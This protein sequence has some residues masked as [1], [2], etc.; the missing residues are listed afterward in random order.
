[1]TP[2]VLVNADG[3][4]DA[5]LSNLTLQGAGSGTGLQ[6]SNG[7]T[8]IRLE[9]TVVQDM[10]TAVSVDGATT[11]LALKNNTVVANVNGFLASN[12]AG[13]D[14]RNTIFAYNSGTAVQYDPG[15]VLQLH[16]YNLYYAN[17]TDLNPNNPGGGERFS[18]P[19]FL[20]FS[21]GDFRTELF[22]PVIDAGTPNDLVPPGAGLAV[23]IGHREQTGSSFFADDDYCDVCLNDGLIW[24]VDAFA[25]VQDAVDAAQADIDVLQI[26]T[27]IQFT[28]G[29]NE[30]VYTESVVI[31]SS[32]QL[33]GRAPDQTVIQGN[34]GPAVTFQ[35]AVNAGVRELA[36]TGGGGDPIGILMRGGS[37]TIAI[38]TNL[39]LDNSVGISVT[40]RSSGNATFNTIIS[41]T[42]GVAL[43]LGTFFNTYEILPGP[44]YLRMLQDNCNPGAILCEERGFLWLDMTN[45][46]VS[47]NA[48]GLSAVGKSVLF[49]DNNL[50]FN[51]VDYTNVI[52]GPNDLLGQDPL[53]SGAYGYLVA[54]SPAVDAAAPGL[55]VPPGGGIAADVGWHELLAAPISVLM[56]QPDESLATESIGVGQVEYAIV[57]V[58]DPSLPITA[59]IP[60]TWTLATLDN[61]G[62]K[63]TYWQTSYNAAGDGYYRFYSRASDLL[64]N[65]E[66]EATDWYD[67]AF[68]VDSNA[69]VVTMTLTP[70]LVNNWLLMEAEVVDY[71][72]DSFDVSETYFMMDGQRLEGQWAVEEWAP[73]GISPRTFRYFFQ[74]DSG[75]NLMPTIQAFAV[76][77]AGNVGSSSSQV[78]GISAGA[79]TWVDTIPPRSIT[80]TQPLPGAYVTDTVLFAGAVWDNGA[81]FSGVFEETD[82][83]TA[84]VALSFDGGLTWQPAS[85]YN[86]GPGDPYYQEAD[87]VW[88]YEWSV[89]AGLDATT[90]PVRVRAID[91]AGLFRSE[92]ISV[93]LDT[94]PPRQF[95]A[96][97]NL[98]R[99]VYMDLGEIITGTWGP[100]LDGSGWVTGTSVVENGD[101]TVSLFPNPDYQV[102][103]SGS[104]GIPVGF[105][106]GV[107]DEAENVIYDNFGL[108][109]GGDVAGRP[110]D[111]PEWAGFQYLERDGLMDIAHNEWLT[112]TE[113]LDDDERPDRVQKLWTTWDSYSAY[114]GWQG[115]SW[116][117]D[118]TMWAY[119]DLFNGGSNLG[120][121]DGRQLPFD[122]DF[123]VSA[124]DAETAY[125]WNYEAG[126]SSWISQTLSTPDINPFQPG[127]AH[128]PGRNET[129][130]RSIFAD[131]LGDFGTTGDVDWSRMFAYATAPDGAVWS[132][133]PTVN[134]L[135]GPFDYYYEWDSGSDPYNLLELPT[136]A[137]N[138]EVSLSFTSDPGEQDTVTADDTILYVATL[139][140]LE[141]EDEPGLQLSLS[142]TAGLTYQTVTGAAGYDCSAGTSCLIDLPVIPALG[143]HV[144]T[145]T[146]MLANDLTGID[147]VTTTAQLEAELP[148]RESFVELVHTI[149]IDPP[150][151]TINRNPGGAIG[152][153]L[154]RVRGT[155]S[156][157]D[158]AGVALV[159]VSTN[160]VDWS[161]AVG[162][163][164][165]SADVTAPPG[166]SWTLHARAMDHHGLLGL[167]WAT[168]L[169]EDTVAPILTPTVPALVGG[170]SF[171][172]LRGTAQDP[173]PAN[174]EVAAI[175]M[176]LDNSSAPWKDGIVYGR[177]PS[178]EQNWL[179]SWVLPAEDNVTHTVR[180]RAT[181]YG[182]NSTTSGWYTTTVDT[183]APAVSVTEYMNRLW[184]ARA[185][186]PWQERSAMV[187]A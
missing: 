136:A 102:S 20:D 155:A 132:A 186:R 104:E 157:G 173:A 174:A 131:Y 37:N 168:V 128:D 177:Q 27:P 83:K 6:V 84:G 166:P 25:N 127:Y 16:Q 34:G 162:T 76:D 142:G 54:G 158:G 120:I 133:F 65:S 10:G 29:I 124:V 154:Q 175:A 70:G 68:V 92:L 129:E 90:I 44:E 11:T 3:V 61:P 60:T 96:E 115:A 42:T 160:G 146:A 99:A 48:V 71:I 182:G 107:R 97:F 4:T 161:P 103:D 172:Q 12:N 181:D 69:P 5:A 50:L 139:A 79:A 58:G 55:P 121:S 13:V 122:A 149:D 110:P 145:I 171:A 95:T 141:D 98:P 30:G 112:P 156:D 59:T 78:V 134:P 51:T 114:I 1:M 82:S 53:L 18:D 143:G 57:P 91:N 80:I 43:G 75:M 183:I 32:V 41:N 152:T 73:D 140:S 39:I 176:Q 119:F 187:A 105:R 28:V 85:S 24:E 72:G 167:P 21:K 117:P 148:V 137:R 26:E 49:S 135:N 125:F 165:W 169:F 106:F 111:Y 130:I 123:A 108:W 46:I 52:S 94:A 163:Q 147:Q 17:G 179:Y 180:F 63:L 113:L 138:P 74:N 86:P 22:S 62:A 101:G 14:I 15:A 170:G 77:G 81:F 93:T 36:L 8:N 88:A 164:E 19:L 2:T 38:D 35:A 47:N 153:G 109:K 185:R 7:A 31:S 100:T 151:V 144:V 178:G 150:T 64:G 23:D 116:G 66:T 40:E 118:G 126:S 184:W 87:R 67:G 9:R 33:I 89:P 45:N 56:G 159:E